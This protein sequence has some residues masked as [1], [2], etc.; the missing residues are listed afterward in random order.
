MKIYKYI[1]CRRGCD[2]TWFEDRGI[3][4]ASDEETARKRVMDEHCFEGEVIMLEETY[5]VSCK[6]W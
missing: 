4:F 6:F 5:V 3:V 2:G 1:H